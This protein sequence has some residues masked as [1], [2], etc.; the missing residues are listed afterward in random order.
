MGV[1]E[2]EIETIAAPIPI[3]AADKAMK[4]CLA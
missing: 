3:P 2:E 1:K 4:G